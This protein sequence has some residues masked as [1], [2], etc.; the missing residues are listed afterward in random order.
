MAGIENQR[1]EGRGKENK[2]KGRG[3][4]REDVPILLGNLDNN[5]IK[6]KRP[7]PR[8]LSKKAIQKEAGTVRKD[9]EVQREVAAASPSNPPIPATS[10]HP[11][12]PTT[13]LPPSKSENISDTEA[14]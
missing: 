3:F 4:I 14:E 13:Q 7:S 6:K 12:T 1:A 11:P 10:L 8:P 9:N 5:D 2:S